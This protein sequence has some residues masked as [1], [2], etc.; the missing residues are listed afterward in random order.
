MKEEDILSLKIET[1]FRVLASRRGKKG[2]G[3]KGKGKGKG[4]GKKGKKK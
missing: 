1:Y 4:K 3:K 2:K